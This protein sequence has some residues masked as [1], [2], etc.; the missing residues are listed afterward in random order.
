MFI[1][2]NG[3]RVE[4]RVATRASDRVI[5]RVPD[6][7]M[8]PSVNS[9]EV[10]RV[11]LYSRG[12]LHTMKVIQRGLHV[13]ALRRLTRIIH[14]QRILFL[15]RDFRLDV[16]A[17]SCYVLRTIN[18]STY[19]ILRL[20]TKGVL[21][22]TN[23]IVTHVDVQTI[24]SS[25]DRRFI[26]FVKSNVLKDLMTRAIGSLVGDL[27]FNHIHD[28]AVRFRLFLGPIGR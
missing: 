24:H 1:C 3:R 13:S 21:C 11:L 14:R 20:I 9:K 15:M 2:H 25:D 16:R 23:R 7:V 18:L 19:P 22:M 4:I 8:I 5:K 28:Q 6:L 12:D 10:L 27:T 26:V 17:A